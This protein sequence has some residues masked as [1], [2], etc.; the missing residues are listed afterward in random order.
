MNKENLLAL[1]RSFR[2][3]N[4]ICYAYRE[5]VFNVLSAD[6]ID[7]ILH[8]IT[9][10]APHT[11]SEALKANGFKDVTESRDAVDAKLGDQ[12]VKM[13][14]VTGDQDK[15]FKIIAQPLTINSLLLRDSGEV[16]DRYEGLQDIYNKTLRRTNAPIQDK[17]SFCSMCF[18]LTL[19][20]GFMPDGAVRDEMKKMVTLPLQ[21]K[22]SFLFSMRSVIKSARFDV[23]YLL[24]TLEYDGL[25][26]NAGTISRE[27]KRQLDAALRKTE[28]DILILFLCY[29]AGLKGEQ[30]KSVNNLLCPKESYD[31]I[32]KFFK[33]GSK[34]DDMKKIFSDKE[35]TIAASFAELLA[36]LTGVDFVINTPESSLFRTFDAE[37]AWIAQSS[38]RV[39]TEKVQEAEERTAENTEQ[40]GLDDMQ[41]LFG[42]EIEES[43]E[44]EDDG[45]DIPM[46]AQSVY[47]LRNPTDNVFLSRKTK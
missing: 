4:I 17:T 39:K 1:L 7:G 36:L 15:L 40:T 42:G 32:S 14:L 28:P 11:V 12:S 22:V 19:K 8:L 20:R 5:T 3:Q 13:K 10:A 24:N 41:G 16:Y 23:G 38:D 46:P 33:D 47:G 26:T 25:F 2:E 30:L 44:V 43:Y 31:K 45:E 21:K 6:K 29:L 27:K 18:E 34:T 37:S 35:L 9:D